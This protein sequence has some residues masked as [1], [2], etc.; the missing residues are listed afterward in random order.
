VSRF[1]AGLTGVPLGRGFSIVIPGSRLQLSSDRASRDPGGV[2]P[3][4]TTQILPPSSRAQAK[5]SRLSP[6]R[7]AGLLRRVA[8]RND[9]LPSQSFRSDAQASSPESIT[10][11][12]AMDSGPAPDG[13]SRRRRSRPLVTSRI[14]VHPP[15]SASP[16]V[17]GRRASARRGRYAARLSTAAPARQQLGAG[18]THAARTMCAA[19]WRSATAA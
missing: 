14:R 6:R 18:R 12:V 8:P 9:D 2:A 1:G 13:A 3:V 10:R 7:Q 16:A 19:P 11:T 4:M 5:Q 17:R 15:H